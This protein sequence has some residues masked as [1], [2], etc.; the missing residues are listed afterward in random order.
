MRLL[1]LAAVLAVG[2]AASGAHAQ[3]AATSTSLT[4]TQGG[5]IVTT[6]KE[7]S[8]VTLTATVVAGS[9]P[10]SPGQVNFCEV[11]AQPLRCTDIRLL[12]TVQLSSAGVAV[13][14]FFPAQGIHTYEAIFVGT[15]T[16]APSTSSGSTLSVS[17]FYPTSTVITYPANIAAGEYTF[18]VSVTGD[19]GNTAPTGTVS[20]LD[21]S[22]G[23]AVLGTATLVPGPSGP[24]SGG[25]GFSDSVT[26]TMPQ[27]DP[28][29][30]SEES[31][32]Y[33]AVA[34]FNGDGKLDV[35]VGIAGVCVL[36]PLPPPPPPPWGVDVLLGNGDGTLTI[37]S[38]TILGD[39]LSLQVSAIAVGDFNQD[40]KPD[41]A[42]VT[43]LPSLDVMLGNG[44]GTFAAPVPLSSSLSAS[45]IFVGT[46]DFNG[47]GIP[48]LAVLN[49][50]NTLN[51]LLGNGDGTFRAGATYPTG[52]NPVFLAVGD[53]NGDG[54]QDIAIANSGDNTLTVL[55]GKGDGTFTAAPTPPSAT[56]P[57][58]MAIAVGDFDGD[59]NLDLAVA[60]YGNDTHRQTGSLAILLGHG[61]GTFTLQIEY[62]LRYDLNSIAVGDFTGSGK[63]DLVLSDQM[64]LVEVM[65]NSGGGQFAGPELPHAAGAANAVA[66]GDFNG[67]GIADILVSSDDDPAIG[68]FTG[69]LLAQVG[70]TTSSLVSTTVV[71]DFFVLGSGFHNLV[72]SYSGDLN[73]SPSISAVEVV[74]AAQARTTLA[75][76][77]NPNTSNYG[78]QVTLTATVV[79]GTIEGY[80]ATGTVTFTIGNTVIGNSPVSNGVATFATT[81]LPAGNDTITATYS[82]DADFEGSTGSTTVSVNGAASATTLTVLP[83]PTLA[84]QSVT[85]TT[86]VVATAGTPTGTVTFL[87]GTTV[88]GQATLDA[89]GGAT[90]S[91]SWS[92]TGT[93]A[94][95]ASY[96]GNGG[97]FPSVSPTVMLTVSGYA[98]TTSLTATPNPAGTGQGVTLIAAVSGVGTAMIPTG[99]VAFLNGSSLL[100][101]AALDATG[102]ATLT[103]TALP[104]GVDGLSAVYGGG[105]QFSG[106]SGTY[107]ET[108]HTPGFSITLS[109]PAISLQEYAN[110]TTSVTLTSAGDFSDNVQ[111]ACVN[112]PA[113]L[114]CAFTPNP[115]NLTAEGTATL[116]FYLDT[117]SIVGGSGKNGP[118]AQSRRAAGWAAAAFGMLLPVG[119]LGAIRRRSA[120]KALAALGLASALALGGCGGSLVSHVPGT[121]PG[122]YTILVTGTGA[123][124]GKTATAQLT[125][126]VTPYW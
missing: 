84:G 38:R 105:P 99:T 86:T 102:H 123:T 47:D 116:S 6:V 125:L 62:G 29:N 58:P 76:T 120:R 75:V 61:D 19:G 101:T 78:Q 33:A 55:L 57:S 8:A 81:T 113:Y 80:S 56:S 109:S 36:C 37:S 100:G 121:A 31:N 114:T 103:T 124:T 7:G 126:T 35:A 71:S 9:T 45:P 20:I 64:G 65:T 30:G 92:A 88:L 97:I 50:P 74:G 111:L 69:V 21:E 67:D 52:A 14:K 110:T 46:G 90:F 107:Q 112:A 94:V 91:T 59:G 108:V 27:P 96:G 16:D 87:S 85:L 26:T 106:S 22:E 3:S 15:H 93:Y 53:F 63:P 51:L 118:L 68:A 34:D 42:F 23:N 122:T 43:T 11:G 117:D 73:F 39:S 17:P 115:T 1:P 83:N 10:V 41:L 89:A 4:V 49:A 104:L 60:N 119:L 13:L 24:S 2:V 54:A 48:D 95:T 82:G 98:T 72:A 12:G 66:A 79:P 25:D 5:N 32:G 77:A 70:S 28:W 40:G 44:D 18:D